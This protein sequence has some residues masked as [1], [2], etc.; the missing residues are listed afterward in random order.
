M[1]VCTRKS[2]TGIDWRILSNGILGETMDG[3]RWNMLQFGT[4]VQVTRYKGRQ[5]QD[6]IRATARFALARS[7]MSGLVAGKPAAVKAYHAGDSSTRSKKRLITVFAVV[8]TLLVLGAVGAAQEI[9]QTTPADDLP[10]EFKVLWETD[11]A[12]AYRW[13]LVGKNAKA[14]EQEKLHP[15]LN[16][17][18]AIWHLPVARN[19]NVFK[20]QFTRPIRK[21][22]N[23]FHLYVKADGDEDSGRKHQGIHKGVDYM[24]T[25]IDGDPKHVSTRLNVFEKDGDSRQGICTVVIRDKTLYL[26]TDMTFQQQDG[27]SIFEFFVLSYVK[28]K[29]PSVSLGYHRGTSAA[30]PNVFDTRLL[31]NPDLLVVNGKVPGWQLVKGS[32]PIEAVL[33]TDSEDDALVVEN[34]YFPERISQTVI[35]VPG[36]YLLRALA[37]TNVFQVHLFAQSMRLPVAVSDDYHWVEL[38]FY[39]PL[40]RQDSGRAVQLGFRYLAR[41]ATGNASRLP[42]RLSAK[43]VELIRLG[44]TVLSEQ[45]AQRLPADPI[46]RMKL[47]QES[48]A[49]NR[50]GKVVFQ[51][52]C[53]GTE[54]WLLTQEGKVDHSYVGH[55]D[56]SHEGKYLQIGLRR[57]PRGLLRT[58]G[59]ERYLNNAWKG[60]VWLFPWEQ[61]RLP[62]GADPADWI[63]TSRTPAGIQLVN[64]VTGESH[65]IEL[66]SRSG[67]R[68]V[69]F[70]GIAS[71]G[72]RGPNISQITYETL[73]WFSE[74]NRSLG[75]SN[76]EGKG[77]ATFPMRTI[78]T[79]P[80]EDTFHADMSS[81][82]G[83]AGDNWRDAVDRD[84]NRYYLF[85]LNREH[86]P[87]HSTNPYQVWALPLAESDHRGL[88]RVVFHPGSVITEYVS[89]QTGMT[90]QPSAKWWDFAA[91]FPWSGDNAILLLED[92]TLIHMSSLGMHSSFAGGSTVSVNCADSG[93]VRYVGTF[94][95]FDRITWPH[96]F[97]RDRD[98]A[99]VASHAEPASPIVMLDL[100][101]T[102]MST[103]ALTNFHDYAMRYKTRWNRNA[104][105]KP[106]F[107]PA[108]TFSPDFTKV[109]FF[110][111]MLTG[112]HPDRKWGDVY[113]AVARY[114]QPPV[115][116]RRDGAGLVW[117][118]PRRH[119]EIQGFRLYRSGESGRNYERVDKNLLTGTRYPLPPDAE[120]FYVLTSVEYSGLESRVFSNEARV[121]DNK[122]FRHFY[123]AAAGRIAKP[124]VPFFDPAKA[125]N[126]YA[127]A[128]TDPDLI[129]KQRLEE[130]LSGSVTMRVAVPKAGPVRILARVRGMSALERATYTTGWPL[131]GKSGT[132]LFSF[133]IDEQKVGSIPVEGFSWCWVPLDAGAVT[134]AAGVIVLEVVTRDTGIAIDGVL[135]TNDPD[136][137]P[138]GRGQ[139]P[140]DM[141]AAPVG[142]RVEPLVAE[143]ERPDSKLTGE[144]RSR[145]KLTW[146]P[147]A[148]P[149]GVS[150]YNVYRSDTE[151]F[152][153]EAE[154]LL[155][156]PSRSVFYD[157]NLEVGR[158]VYYR[159]RAV[160]AWG[161]RSPASDPLAW[162]IHERSVAKP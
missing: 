43:K 39:V 46:H 63:A 143:D 109:V 33:A 156:S 44:D 90:R 67:W 77:F 88:L 139:V 20:F 50:P 113:V 71:Y 55:P 76:V 110:S 37:K 35:L 157:V 94:P 146:Q 104:Y 114:P 11:S 137:V 56:F 92:D 89:S 128:I 23:V 68:I 105:H 85:E 57:S 159:L 72:G 27:H 36:H 62:E 124:M 2:A 53:I 19:R 103:L 51:D 131:S 150:H 34:L 25:L 99:V 140:E 1:G 132:G 106:M 111:S 32:R 162:T 6:Q 91:G 134:L 155:G 130:G 148:A 16:V 154:T 96:E 80:D 48:P 59:S 5:C 65:R 152:E 151:T 3:I 29:G 73:V 98:Y 97:R 127:V 145:I 42:A 84:G 40:S 135:V 100:E 41:P 126:A 13:T 66:P 144:H 136:F 83:K 107:R 102:T 79:R 117:K 49:W 4:A 141:A 125:A 149:Q 147:V 112:D 133:R 9:G 86:L 95:K 12:G 70:P 129:Y 121:G 120:G 81:V 122:V 38:P 158:T 60:I 10:T 87:D 142:L 123:R 18:R 17:I 69:H 28:G 47:I 161:N 26:A 160:D 118:Q 101:H 75:R 115:D 14:S 74:K 116:L 31:A 78:S 61:K 54:L 22:N 64:V 21:G 45:W 24:F 7:R 138:H 153:A 52:A 119:A 30:A 15:D 108:P 8:P 82:G 58:D 93:E